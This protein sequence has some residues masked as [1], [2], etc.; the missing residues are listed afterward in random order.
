MSLTGKQLRFLELER[1]KDEFK[2]YQ[3]D[4]ENATTELIQELGL[5][6]FFQD[7]QGTVYKLIECPG[8]FVRFER[9]SYLRTKRP[10]EERGS[11]SVK[12][13]KEHGFQV[14]QIAMETTTKANLLKVQDLLQRLYKAVDRNRYDPALLKECI[15]LVDKA[16]EEKT[17]SSS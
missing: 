9:Y 13:A 15:E 17:E 10:G 4:L 1:R 3:E 6:S 2:K 16:L 14:D 11:L 5:G 7:E 8:R 12:E